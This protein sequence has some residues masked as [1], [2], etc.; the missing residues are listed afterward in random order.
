MSTLTLEVL[1]PFTVQQNGRVTT[2]HPGQHMTLSQEKAR[3]VLDR[4]GGK[5]RVLEG[6]ASPIE[7]QPA[8]PQPQAKPVYW[9]R[10]SLGAI[11]GPATVEFVT[12]TEEGLTSQYW[13]AVVHE[14]LPLFVDSIW[15]RSK[16]QFDLQVVPQVVELVPQCIRVCQEKGKRPANNHALTQKVR[17]ETIEQP[18]LGLSG[19]G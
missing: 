11:V 14:G 3:R 10:Q 8:R 2:W 18:P 4:V 19:E 15:L 5:V 13:V 17:P 12:Q 6:D 1:A 7:R 16:R 9:L